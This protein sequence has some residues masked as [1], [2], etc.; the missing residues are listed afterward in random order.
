MPKRGVVRFDK[1]GKLSPRYIGPFEILERVGTIAY[2]LTLPQSLLSV[3][4]VFHVSLLRKYA[5]DPTHVV[6]WGELVVDADRT[7]EEG[8]VRIMDSREQVLRRMTVRL[9]KVLWQHRG[10]EETTL[11]REDTMH[12]TYPFLFK[13]EGTL[14]NRLVIKL[15]VIMHV[16]VC[17]CV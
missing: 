11:E 9:V 15:L 5:P 16:I 3:H 1:R 13:D 2:R 12:A 4:E 14:F 8:S 10:L 7:F 6:D 17:I